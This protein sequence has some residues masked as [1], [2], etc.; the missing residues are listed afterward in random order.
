MANR[1]TLTLKSKR[2]RIVASDDALLADLLDQGSDVDPHNPH[3]LVQPSRA[4]AGEFRG[5]N[6]A[7]VLE[8]ESAD[9]EVAGERSILHGRPL[10]NCPAHRKHSSRPQLGRAS[11]APMSSASTR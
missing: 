10:D 3:K 5:A 6:F 1:P 4:P 7:S 11:C 8:K 9:H 2:D